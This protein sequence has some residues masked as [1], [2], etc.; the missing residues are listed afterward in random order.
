MPA[1]YD[2]YDYP[3]Y[4]KKRDYEHYA[5]FLA[6]KG[7]LNQIPNV[8]RSIEVGAGVGRLFP[9]YL[10]RVKK[11]FLTDP[12]A[13]LLS[14]ATKK[15]SQNKRVKYL[16]SKL[17]NI[18]KKTK[19]KTFDLAVMVRVIHHIEDIDMAFEQISNLLVKGGYLILEFPNKNHLKSNIRHFLKGDLTHPLNIFPVDIRCKENIKNKTLPFINYHPDQIIEKLKNAGFEIVEVRSVSNIR[20]TLIKKF[21]PLHI[22]LDIE[23]NIQI[24]FAKLHFGPSI[25]VLSRKRR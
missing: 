25:F 8:N 23:K 22:L 7:L 13:K 5:E 11:A 4:W 2:N 3:S 20:S 16:Q 10:F 15:Y 9:S 12:S 1:A 18:K 24:P 14:I 21:F 19:S 17:K 6:I